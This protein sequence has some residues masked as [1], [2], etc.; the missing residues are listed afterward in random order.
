[1]LYK[2]PIIPEARVI[3][4]NDEPDKTKYIYASDD[5]QDGT[6]ITIC[7]CCNA[8]WHFYLETQPPRYCRRCGEYMGK[9]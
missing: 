7:Q 2:I 8:D 4:L 6:L 1:M 5:T 9:D 3:Q